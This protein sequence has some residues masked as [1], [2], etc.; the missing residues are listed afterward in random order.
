M[1]RVKEVRFLA[2]RDAGTIVL[3]AAWVPPHS[4]NYARGTDS[5][6]AGFR[7]VLPQ[8]RGHAAGGFVCG[9]ARCGGA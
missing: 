8:R 3:G 6:V 1:T 9:M 7:V 4:S 2:G 5:T